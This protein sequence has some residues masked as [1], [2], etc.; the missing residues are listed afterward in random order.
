MTSPSSWLRSWTPAST[1]SSSGP[2]RPRWRPPGAGGA[3]SGRR[4]SAT[5]RCSSSTTGPGSRSPS[6]PTGSTWGRTTCPSAIARRILGPDGIIGLSTNRPEQWDSAPPEADY[7]CAGPV[8]ET[9]TKAGR[10]AAGLDYVRY[11][12]ESDERRPWFAIGGINGENVREVSRCRRHPDRRAPCRGERAR[13]GGRGARAPGGDLAE[14]GLDDDLEELQP[15]LNGGGFLVTPLARA[16]TVIGTSLIR[17][18]WRRASM[19][20]SLVQNWSCCRISFCSVSIGWRGSPFDTSV[21]RVPVI[22]DTS[23]DST[24]MP[25]WRTW[26]S[27]SYAPRTREP[28]TMSYSPRRIGSTRSRQLVR[29]VLPVGVDRSRP[30]PRRA[31]GPARSRPA[32]PGRR[33][34]GSGAGRR[35]LR[36][37]GRRGRRLILRGVVDDEGHDGMAVHLGSGI[38]LEDR[39]DVRRLVV[40]G[41]DYH[42][43]LSGRQ[44]VEAGPSRSEWS[45][46]HSMSSWKSRRSKVGVGLVPQNEQQ[47]Q[48]MLPNTRSRQ[49]PSPPPRW[50]LKR[51]NSGSKNDGER[52]EQ[53]PDQPERARDQQVQPGDPAAPEPPAPRSRR[54]TRRT[55]RRGSG[56]RSAQRWEASTGDV[57]RGRQR[58]RGRMWPGMT[59][60]RYR[61]IT[62]NI[63]SISVSD[64][65]CGCRPRSSRWVFIAR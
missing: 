5:A 23:R 29:V 52:C 51:L 56:G 61:S 46:I 58:V 44:A 25:R 33:R 62:L 19:I 24:G 36:P 48:T 55:G 60:S 2:R 45:P 57:A 32:R 59:R 15:Y 49:Q 11:A 16:R 10:P 39:A 64:R 21:I 37:R 50:K 3:Y 40:R 35:A 34:G 20:I 1:W 43:A 8:W 22:I 13:S 41:E 6:R 42:D 26:L 17:A 9:P 54:G 38:W 18:W 28:W 65:K 7:L 27:C 63:D 12:A 30:P 53:Q 31:A 4:T 47:E 14:P